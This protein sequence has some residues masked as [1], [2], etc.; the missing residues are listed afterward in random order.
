MSVCDSVVRPFSTKQERTVRHISNSSKASARPTYSGCPATAT[1]AGRHFSTFEFSKWQTIETRQDRRRDDPC[2][3]PF[4][5]EYCMRDAT[6]MP[7]R[8]RRTFLTQIDVIVFSSVF[9]FLCSLSLTLLALLLCVDLVFEPSDTAILA[10]RTVRHDLVRGRP[11]RSEVSQHGL[12]QHSLLAIR[13]SEI[14][15]R[16]NVVARPS[17]NEYRVP[18]RTVAPPAI[19]C[20]LSCDDDRCD[21]DLL[22]EASDRK[23]QA[24]SVQDPGQGPEQMD[25]ET[26]NLDGDWDFLWRLHDRKL[27][28]ITLHTARWNQASCHMPV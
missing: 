19:T 27:Q 24:A 14:A 21:C 28:R 1:F 4:S 7:N 17:C 3:L 5:L 15:A 2:V 23:V 20:T 18:R 25:H 26:I 11:F 13:E 8:L 9:Q 6:R 22:L 10:A 16:T 12:I